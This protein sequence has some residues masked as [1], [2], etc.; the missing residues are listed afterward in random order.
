MSAGTSRIASACVDYPNWFEHSNWDIQVR[1]ANESMAGQTVAK[2]TLGVTL[3]FS[4][5]VYNEKNIFCAGKVTNDSDRARMINFIL[6]GSSKFTNPT[7]RYRIFD[8]SITSLFIT[9]AACVC[10]ERNRRQGRF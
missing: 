9:T 10:G 2:T 4:D 1:L 8:L 7:R 5:V 6:G 3:N